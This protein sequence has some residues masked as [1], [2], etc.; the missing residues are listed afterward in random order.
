[1]SDTIFYE[2][3]FYGSGIEG[4]QV[5]KNSAHQYNSVI[6]KICGAIGTPDGFSKTSA[7]LINY[8]HGDMIFMGRCIPGPPDRYNRRTL[9]FHII[10]G[11]IQKNIDGNI[12]A[13]TLLRNNVFIDRVPEQCSQIAVAK[14]EKLNFTNESPFIWRKTPLAIQCNSPQN[15]LIEQLLGKDVND[16]SWASFSFAPLPNFRLYAISEYS[17]TPVNIDCCDVKGNIIQNKEQFKN[18]V[19]SEKQQENTVVE[20]YKKRN[21]LLPLFIASLLVNAFLIYQNISLNSKAVEKEI[22]KEV[23]KEVP[24]PVQIKTVEKVVQLPP[25]PVDIKKIKTEVLVD[26]AK[27]FPRKDRIV[28]WE[29]ELS[30]SENSVLRLKASNPQAKEYRLLQQFKIYVEFVNNN[31]LTQLNEGE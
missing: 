11:N 16:Y 30:R 26:I 8:L 5:L 25:K 29:K 7:F 31:I 9:F 27:S 18:K 17:S 22:I 20:K 10:Y 4:Y 6:E 28:D 19:E 21:L 12:N 24:G 14:N 13:F 2:Q 1:M 15:E 23:V 3:A